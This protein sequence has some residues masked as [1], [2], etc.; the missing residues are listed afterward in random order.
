[1]FLLTGEGD[2]DSV[3]WGG[4]PEEGDG[5]LLAGAGGAQGGEQQAEI[6]PQ[7]PQKGQSF[8]R[9]KEPDRPAPRHFHF[10][11]EEGKVSSD[12]TIPWRCVIERKLA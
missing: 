6:S 3:G 11:D 7:R 12:A 8:K 4:D 2:P 5:F 10:L 1:M 9:G